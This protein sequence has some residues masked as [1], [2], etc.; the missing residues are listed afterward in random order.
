[1]QQLVPFDRGRVGSVAFPTS[2]M[3]LASSPRLLQ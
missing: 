1:V 3:R 2:L